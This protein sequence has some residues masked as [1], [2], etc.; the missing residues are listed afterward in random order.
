MPPEDL[1]KVI[2]HARLRYSKQSLND[3]VFIWL[4]IKSNKKL[5]AKAAL[6]NSQND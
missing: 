1:T 3:V 2:H 6:K 5:F 4:I